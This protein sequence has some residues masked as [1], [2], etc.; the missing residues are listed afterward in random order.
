MRDL[1]E[2]TK[3]SIHYAVGTVDDA[4]ENGTLYGGFA[5][6]Y[7]YTSP[8]GDHYV[9]CAEIDRLDGKTLE[10]KNFYTVTRY[11]N[12]HIGTRLVIMLLNR[13]FDHNGIL[14]FKKYKELIVRPEPLRSFPEERY[15][16]MDADTLCR[17][18]FR[19]GFDIPEKQENERLA[20][21]SGIKGRIAEDRDEGDQTA[22][23]RDEED[24][25]AEDRTEEDQMAEDRTEEDR[26][27][28]DQTTGNP[29]ESQDEE[30][31]A[32]PEYLVFKL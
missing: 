24:Q 12:K 7:E 6:D 25:T 4:G 28:E 19:M 2:E 30:L 15:E 21:A 17:I 22:E 29:A 27:E 13:I 11:R 32:V 8:A 20:A 23:D 5:E 16:D 31:P 26:T 18:L 3:G 1:K 10:L 14:F 9:C